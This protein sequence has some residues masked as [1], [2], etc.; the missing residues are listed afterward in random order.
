M[1][2]LALGVWGIV[3]MVAMPISSLSLLGKLWPM[4]QATAAGAGFALTLLFIIEDGVTWL[5]WAATACGALGALAC[6]SGAAGLISER[7]GGTT[8]R[9]EA[10][11]E[12]SAGFLGVLLPLFVVAVPLTLLVAL[13]IGTST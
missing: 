7:A 6:A 11:E 9:V 12:H 1:E 2:W 4:A 5:A 3:V 13:A 10:L 8:M